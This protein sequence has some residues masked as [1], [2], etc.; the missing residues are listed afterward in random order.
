MRTEFWWG[1]FLE[2]TLLEQHK[3]D[4]RILR[5]WVARMWTG[6]KWIRIESH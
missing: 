1:N 5:K 2:S 6:W 3:G 4:R